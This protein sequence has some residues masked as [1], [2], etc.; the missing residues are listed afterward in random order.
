[1]VHEKRE[2]ILRC[3]LFYHLTRRDLYKMMHNIYA[4]HI[5]AQVPKEDMQ[6]LVASDNEVDRGNC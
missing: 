1:M 2:H 3:W 5:E 4:L 6:L